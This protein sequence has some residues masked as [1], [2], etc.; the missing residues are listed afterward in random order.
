LAEVVKDLT[1]REATLLV[2][3]RSTLTAGHLAAYVGE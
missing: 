3:A 2:A 1:R